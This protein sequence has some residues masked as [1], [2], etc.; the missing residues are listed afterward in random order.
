MKSGGG[1]GE[2]LVAYAADGEA[3]HAK[4]LAVLKIRDLG[5]QGFDVV[6]APIEELRPAQ[7]GNRCGGFLD[8]RSALFGGDQDFLD[9]VVF[10]L[11][12]PF[13]GF[14]GFHQVRIGQGFNRLR[15]TL[16][17]G[18]RLSQ[19]GRGCGE[20]KKQKQRKKRE[21]LLLLFTVFDSFVQEDLKAPHTS[22]DQYSSETEFQALPFFL[23]TGLLFRFSAELP[24]SRSAMWLTISV[25]PG[26]RSRPIDAIGLAVES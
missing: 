13:A 11:R 14:L 8:I 10:G 3:G 21:P 19:Q 15:C 17:P 6:D 24:I 9:T 1:I 20:E 26:L 23:E 16:T 2:A 5:G 25:F 18:F 4:G 22:R 12:G 7:R